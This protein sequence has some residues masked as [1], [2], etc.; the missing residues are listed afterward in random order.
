MRQNGFTLIEVLFAISILV[1]GVAALARV[2]V[3]AAGVNRQARLG[4]SASALAARKMEQLNALAWGFDAFGAP[5]TDTSTDTTSTPERPNGGTGLA[6]SPPD[7]LTRNVAGYCDFV[8]AT[9]RLLGGG[10]AA[11]GGTAY[12]RRWS[13]QPL[14]SNPAHTIVLQVVVLSSATRSFDVATERSA[15]E[16]RVTTVRTR[17]AS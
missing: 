7:V 13:I 5:L 1:V 8:D 12:I 2:S 15:D 14:A 9:G 17:K 4:S 3:V 6:S 16:A 11:P 10:T